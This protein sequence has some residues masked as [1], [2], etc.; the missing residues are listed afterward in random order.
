MPTDMPPHQLPLPSTFL[1][2]PVAIDEAGRV[3]LFERGDSGEIARNSFLGLLTFPVGA[4]DFER[5]RKIILA[6]DIRALHEFQMEVSIFYC[7]DCG[8]CYCGEH[9]SWWSAFD[10]EEG[11]DWH[12]SIRGFCPQGHRQM[13]QD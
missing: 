13:L 10:D 3:D 2:A 6:G 11:F 5:I 8:T 4:E 9:W 1:P 7:P 12:D